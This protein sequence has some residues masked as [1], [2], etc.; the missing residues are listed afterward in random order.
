MHYFRPSN[1]RGSVDL[2]WLKSKHTFSFGHYY[3]A[4][5]MGI[6]ALRVINDDLV[7]GGA[8]FSTH[9]HQDM[10]IISYVLDG[11]I[12]HK[13]NF[14][15]QYQVPAGDI[16]IMSAGRGVTHSEY[17]ASQTDSLKFLQIWIQPNVK[18]IEPRYEQKSVAQQGPLTPLV[19]SD[20]REGSLKMMQDANLYR[21]VLKPNEFIVLSAKERAAYLH[22]IQ[23]DAE[24]ANSQMYP[25]DG[26]GTTSSEQLTV[27]SGSSGL[28]A[29]WFDLPPN[30]TLS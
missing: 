6:S 3:D 20:G 21:L 10:E 25:G 11:V 24:V 26:F 12:E 9:G 17:N 14:G 22:I 5:H 1:E 13:D 16:Q 28:T 30:Q 23:G 4:E 18:G 15:N 29:L 27:K 2:G 8:G 7:K 19:T